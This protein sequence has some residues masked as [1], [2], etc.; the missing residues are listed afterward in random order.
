[1]TRVALAV[2]ALAACGR[3]QGTPDQDLGSL[4][5]A[6]K[7]VEAAIDVARAATD[8]AELSRALARPYRDTIAAL[9]PHTVTVATTTTTSS[10][11]TVVD[12]RS[13]KATL[14]LG[15]GPVF[16]GTYENSGDYGRE[17]IFVDKTLFLRPRYQRWHERAPEG[18]DEPATLRDGFTDAITATWELLAP[19]AELSDK[20]AITV[21]GRAGRL[22]EIHLSSHPAAMPGESLAQKKW[23]VN[24]T[25]V[26]V[27][28]QI[29]LDAEK[30]V[31][32]AI[33]LTG[34][35]GFSRDGHP[36]TMKLSVKS[37]I[38][39]LGQP[40]TI[41]RPA[42]AEVVATPER[43][44]EVDD[45]DVLLEGIAPAAAIAKPKDPP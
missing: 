14:E 32:L 30:G 22:I 8:P 3:A 4:V 44:K 34:S 40:A 21:G 26:A 23:R 1:M 15:V 29:V 13:D 24:R 31:P 19:G 33:D 35:I 5:I 43:A 2:L 25:V 9:G 16:H 7:P 11:D 38:D 12:D 28:G 17:T 6:P 36:M 41:A 37:A 45:R 39:K 20:G 27:A 42:T 10:G 18:A